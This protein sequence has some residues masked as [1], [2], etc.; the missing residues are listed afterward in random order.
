MKNALIRS[1]EA[2]EQI[3]ILGD[4][5][6]PLDYHIT[7]WKGEI[8]DFIIL[9]QD[10]FDDI[11]AVT[12]IKRQRY[13]MDVVIDIYNTDFEF[14]NFEDIRMYFKRIINSL[15]QMNYSKFDSDKF[16][17]NQKELNKIIEERMVKE[18]AE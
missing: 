13:M 6:V 4:D 11:D 18:I 5:G 14:E 10:A 7:F 1:R 9:Q 15:K 8:I 16:K 12:P 2:Y 3:N 17:Q